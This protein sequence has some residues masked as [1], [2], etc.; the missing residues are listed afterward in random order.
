[1]EFTNYDL[2][3]LADIPTDNTRNKGIKIVTIVWK[4]EINK[5]S[6]AFKR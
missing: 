6:E 4:F 5:V 1:M 3:K 2:L